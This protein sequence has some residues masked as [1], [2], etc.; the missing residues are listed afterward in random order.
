MEILTNVSLLPYNTF[1]INAKTEF[2]V[3]LF[4]SQD[5]LDLIET[6]EFKNN[7][8]FILWWWS[9]I[10]LTKDYDGLTIKNSIPGKKI[11]KES[12][13]YV[14]IKAGAGED[15][16]KFVKWCVEQDFGGIENLSLVPGSIGASP[17]QNIWAYGT[18]AKDII[19]EVVWIN[20]ET[21][22]EQ[23]LKNSECNFAYRNSIF[24]N[25]LKN[26]F[27]ITHV[28][29]KLTKPW[30][31]KLNLNYRDI[32]NKLEKMHLDAEDMEVQDISEIIVDIREGKLPDWTQTGTAGSFFKNPVVS[33]EEFDK[34]KQEH[35]EILGFD[36]E[37]KIKLSAG[38]LI[39]LSGLKWVQKWNVWTYQNH[40]LILV[41]NGKW[42][43]GEVVKLA[44]E[45]QETVY[46]KFGV[47]LEPEVNYIK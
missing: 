36:F 31:H 17:V 18:E 35:E 13:E 15:W 39:Q 23:T 21:K 34:L 43:G 33:K 4:K 45:I 10:L 5:V 46:N 41:N 19:D 26:K 11:I 20:L 1:Q 27:I 12:D 3:E 30:H 38:Q 9:N 14:W 24:K 40:A 25:E 16:P 32:Q 22:Q 47:K 44:E 8:F 2:F 7:K 29:Y 6:E 42:S 37:D 28:I